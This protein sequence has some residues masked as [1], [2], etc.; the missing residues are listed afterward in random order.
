VLSG[1]AWLP[2]KP[3]C[4]F[5]QRQ[6]L[7]TVPFENLDIHWKRPIVIDTKKFYS[8]IVDEKRGGFCYELNGLFNE[9]LKD[10][11]FRTRIV[12][13]CVHD[14][15]GGFTPEYDHAAI[16][17]TIGETEY[18][19]DVGFGAFAA[20]PLRFVPD[21]EQEDAA[22]VFTIRRFAD[23]YF[24]IAKKE[25]DGWRTEYKFKTLGHDL[26]EFSE[27]C[28]FQQYSPNSHFLKGKICSLM[29]ENGRRTLTDKN[30]IVTRNSEKTEIPVGTEA[31]FD[32]ILK[33]EFGIT[34]D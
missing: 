34:K 12:S 10:I 6:H 28:D 8:K 21:I 29:T 23:D 26:S 19:A 9:L 33:R 4:G 13:A 20:D 30:F 25:P 31:E 15:S 22:G 1:R 32:L 27:R 11:G 16:I 18:L 14:G 17:V 24:E 5:L 3:P 2:T 7:L